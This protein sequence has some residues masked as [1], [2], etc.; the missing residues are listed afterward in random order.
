MRN[1]EQSGDGEGGVLK[2]DCVELGETRVEVGPIREESR[3]AHAGQ[4]EHA[5]ETEVDPVKGQDGRVEA[6]NVTCVCGRNI[7]LTCEYME[8]DNEDENA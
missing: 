5:A 2:G 4:E 7:H 6:I 1:S 8:A 3:R